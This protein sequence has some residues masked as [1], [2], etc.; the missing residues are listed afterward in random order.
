M[1]VNDEFSNDELIYCEFDCGFS[2]KF[3]FS[4]ELVTL[5]IKDVSSELFMDC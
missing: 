1:S 2:E 4:V 3:G 5:L